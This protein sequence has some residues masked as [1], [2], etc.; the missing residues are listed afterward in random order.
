MFD[1]EERMA[2]GEEKGH[3]K[4]NIGFVA[5][6]LA[7]RAREHAGVAARN[8]RGIFW[9]FKRIIA[10]INT[11]CV[12]PVCRTAHTKYC[13]DKR[14]HL[15]ASARSVCAR[16]QCARAL[17]LLRMSELKKQRSNEHAQLSPLIKGFAGVR[18]ARC[19]CC[20][21]AFHALNSRA[22][23]RANDVL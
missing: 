15:C 17:E 22:R 3:T 23:P 2:G 16:S 1:T 21:C 14:A 13:S 4:N 10:F 8:E 5:H 6:V 20:V 12:T 19:A 7:A 9:W 18:D 11:R